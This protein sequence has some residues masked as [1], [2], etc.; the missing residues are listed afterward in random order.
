MP[1]SHVEFE[2]GA[3]N[4]RSIKVREATLPSNKIVENDVSHTSNFASHENLERDATK[5][6]EEKPF[7]Y[8]YGLYAFV[9]LGANVA[10]VSTYTL[11]PWRDVF[12]DQSAWW[13]QLVRYGLILMFLRPTLGYIREAYM[14]FKMESLMSFACHFKFW[15]II[16]S[17]YIIPYCGFYYYWTIANGLNHPMPFVDVPCFFISMFAMYG[18]IWFHFPKDLRMEKKFRKR[19]K[20]Y[21]TYAFS[22]NLIAFQEIIMDMAFINLTAYEIESGLEAQWLMA[23]IIPLFRGFNEWLLPKIFHK[24][25]GYKEGWTKV[26]EDVPAT[27]VMETCIAD[28]YALY[29]AVRLGWAKQLTVMCIL[30][31]EFTINLFYCFRII[32]LHN[33]IANNGNNQDEQNKILKAEKES[34]VISLITV[35]T[36]EVLIP[37]GYS[38]AYATAFYGPNATLFVGVKSTY[39]GYTE[40]EIES[41]FSFLFTMFAADTFGGALI[42]AIL[43]WKCNINVLKEYC[44]I[45]QKYWFILLIY[46]SSDLLYVSCVD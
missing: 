44:K 22:W 19:L 32:K 27:F 25:L 18:V 46:M 39:F 9:I 20:Y 26:D 42:S 12:I 34:A 10:W 37:L 11:I 24:A 35:E 2:P 3:T 6:V 41:V 16:S 5:I 28:V 29:V 23:L 43:A 36:I 1:E 4:I 13:E 17:A 38:L 21:I 40:Q 14:V 45:M 15:S 8:L 30:L 7:S 33:K 31:V